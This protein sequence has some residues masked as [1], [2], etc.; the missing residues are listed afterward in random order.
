MI[1]IR[2]YYA[3]DC[4]W[5]ADNERRVKFPEIISVGVVKLDKDFN[6]VDKFYRVVKPVLNNII[7]Q[8]TFDLTHL[9]PEELDSGITFKEC[10]DDLEA[11]LD[12]DASSIIYAWGNE[13]K[14]IFFRN[15]RKIKNNTFIPYCI[16]DIQ[17]RICKDIKYN[18][19]RVSDQI[20]IKNLKKIYHIEDIEDHNAL[21]DAVSLGLIL[22]KTNKNA[23]KD[24]SLLEE[25]FL[26]NYYHLLRLF[27]PELIIE[28]PGS[29]LLF[30]LKTLLTEL[31][32]PEPAVFNI[33]KK[34]LFLKNKNSVKVSEI[35]LKVNYILQSGRFNFSF[36]LMKENECLRTYYLS[37]EDKKR[38]KIIRN[39][40]R[41]INSSN[42]KKGTK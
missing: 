42:N 34:Y 4:E 15:L 13:D 24:E 36:T 7:P 8:F 14:T 1:L 33:K 31:G 21:N 30:Q 26:K 3:L 20:S 27:V 12:H 40:V 38:L 22:E 41:K 35:S 9:T 2:N 37:I 32:V 28:N 5:V 39:L 25:L 11:F 17:D 6:I 19:L 23:E 18:G 16:C 10:I 29:E